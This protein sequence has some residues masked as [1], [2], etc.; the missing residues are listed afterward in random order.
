MAGGCGN[1]DRHSSR[2]PWD[3]LKALYAADALDG[4]GKMLKVIR[5]REAEADDS[6]YGMAGVEAD[7]AEN[8]ENVFAMVKNHCV[9]V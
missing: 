2:K 9:S 1:A 4:I 6:L 8:E 7:A 5:G 3:R